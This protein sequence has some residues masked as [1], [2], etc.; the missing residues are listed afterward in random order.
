MIPASA[1]RSTRIAAESRFPAKASMY[2]FTSKSSSFAV[3]RYLQLCFFSV[4]YSLKSLITE[5]IGDSKPL[6]PLCSK[7]CWE[8]CPVVKLRPPTDPWRVVSGRFPGTTAAGA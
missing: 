4:T 2:K 3:P 8:H 1:I 6:E 7:R 5:F